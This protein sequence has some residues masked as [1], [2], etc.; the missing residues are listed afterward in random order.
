MR[1]EGACPGPPH[2][3]SPAFVLRV[4]SPSFPTPTSEQ[5]EHFNGGQFCFGNDKKAPC[6]V[7]PGLCF[8]S[9]PFV[10]ACNGF[11]SEG[12]RS[13]TWI[14]CVPGVFLSLSFFWQQLK[15]LVIFECRTI[16]ELGIRDHSSAFESLSGVS[17]SE[18]QRSQLCD[19]LEISQ[20]I[21]YVC[22]GQNISHGLES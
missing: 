13:W 22:E 7:C 6:Q 1:G 19:G 12:Q 17:N 10:R 9:P 20:L 21:V 3:L 2:P 18:W 14:W 11:C 4:V 16:G 8:V 5:Q 15:L